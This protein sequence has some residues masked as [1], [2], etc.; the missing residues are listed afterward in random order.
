MTG[1]SNFFLKLEKNLFH[2]TGIQ[3]HI[4]LQSYRL[5]TVRLQKISPDAITSFR[6]KYNSI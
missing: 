5:H 3:V 6:A 2:Q 1:F 4:L